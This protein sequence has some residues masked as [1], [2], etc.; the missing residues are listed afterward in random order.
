MRLFIACEASEDV[1][2]E[3]QALQKQ[4]PDASM[5]FPKHFHLTFKFLGDVSEEKAEK[6]K[7]LLANIKF[8]K[9]ELCLKPLEVF[10]PDNVRVVWAG[11]H[12]EEPL[13]ALQQQVDEALRD[14]FPKEDRFKP[15]LTIARVKSLKDRNAF[16]EHI[17]NLKVKELCFTIDKFFL[18]ESKLTP[19]GP[20]YTV[21]RTYESKV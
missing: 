11:L 12:P 15:H 10:A 6:V 16:I 19:E 4:L 5:T 17:K 20:E 18:I 14:L 7:E 3:L 2:E 13:I 9:F 1:S 8:D 21:L